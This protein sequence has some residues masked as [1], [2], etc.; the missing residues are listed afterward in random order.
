MV[1][2]SGCGLA[3]RLEEQGRKLA[4]WG[5]GGSDCAHTYVAA[6]PQG[7]R[8]FVSLSRP[9]LCQLAHLL[10][11][12]GGPP[13]LCTLAQARGGDPHAAAQ[14]AAPLCDVKSPRRRRAA[15]SGRC[16]TPSGPAANPPGILQLP[17]CS[18]FA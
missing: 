16:L 18:A 13:P 2:L 4:G 10:R 14:P 7:V 1:G 11:P 6:G 17:R 12:P 5:L 8:A 9:G 15:A 3:S